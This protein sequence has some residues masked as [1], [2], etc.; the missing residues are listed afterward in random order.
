M[1]KMRCGDPDNFGREKIAS[2]RGQK[3]TAKKTTPSLRHPRRIRSQ[4]VVHRLTSE[5][6]APLARPAEIRSTGT[7]VWPFVVPLFVLRHYHCEYTAFNPVS[8]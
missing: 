5:I 1:G 8:V 3:K 2:V 7:S 6:T 4:R